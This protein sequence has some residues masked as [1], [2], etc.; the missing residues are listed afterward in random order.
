MTCFAQCDFKKEVSQLRKKLSQ[1]GKELAALDPDRVKE[2][3]DKADRRVLRVIG[4]RDCARK[5]NRE[6]QEMVDHLNCKSQ[7]L[8]DQLEWAKED[9]LKEKKE[10]KAA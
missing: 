3:L 9:L 4:E 8:K 7:T 10:G 5:R 6:L 1:A 2:E